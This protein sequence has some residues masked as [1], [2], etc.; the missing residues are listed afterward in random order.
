MTFN[1]GD[2]PVVV[3]ATSTLSPD[4]LQNQQDTVDSNKQTK[5]GIL[6]G[7]SFKIH[8]HGFEQIV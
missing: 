6:S 8:I 5:Q 3:N 2:E 1:N 4:L 7:S